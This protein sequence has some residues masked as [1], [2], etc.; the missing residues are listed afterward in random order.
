[1]SRLLAF[2]GALAITFSTFWLMQYLIAFDHPSHT[3][4]NTQKA[5][6]ISAIDKKIP[7]H[8]KHK[9]EIRK[10]KNPKQP[11]PPPS[12]S[13]STP[14][15]EIKNDPSLAFSEPSFE[16]DSS[17]NISP[18]LMMVGGGLNLGETQGR[19]D[20]EGIEIRPLS[21]KTPNIPAIA[22]D[23]R[24][25]G[26]VEVLIN[27]DSTG[28]VTKLRVQNAEPKGI[29]EEEA[30]RAIRGWIYSSSSLRSR[31]IVQRLE[32]DWREYVYNTL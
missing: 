4:Q 23:Q 22:Y 12:A 27:I 15:I 18:E 25:S 17:N 14:V 1:M 26:W 13:L 28:R 7:E 29:F 8:K 31:Q 20:Q 11:K 10:L 19:R 5:V 30:L 32:F 2:T 3:Q 21:T 6:I 9:P 16:I 24:I